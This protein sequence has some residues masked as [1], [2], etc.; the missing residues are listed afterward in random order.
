[1]S[2]K[3]QGAG[4]GDYID[5][6]QLGDYGVLQKKDNRPGDDMA[7]ERDHIPSKQA[8]IEKAKSLISPKV[9]SEEAIK[10]IVANSKAIVIPRMAHQK[11][12]PT[13]G[14][15]Q[16]QK[17]EEMKRTLWDADHLSKAAQRD[18]ESMLGKHEYL[19]EPCRTKYEE[20]ANEI[21]KKTDKDYEAFLWRMIKNKV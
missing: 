3:N 18:I 1:M 21:L 15:R 17:I 9:L 7:Y 4:S 11:I 14:G 12:S 8:L 20:S 5:C 16:R 10:R 13:F 6:G 2:G 19:P